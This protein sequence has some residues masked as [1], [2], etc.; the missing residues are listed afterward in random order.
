[1][2]LAYDNN[3]QGYFKYS[4]AELTLTSTRDL[5]SQEVTTLSLW[6]RGDPTNA[7]ERLYVVIANRTGAPAVAYHDDASATQIG[8]WTQWVIPLPAF[9]NQG[10]NLTDVDRIAIGLG[11]IGNTTIPGGSGKIYFDDIRLYR[12]G[13]AT[14]E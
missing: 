11:T 13:A 7:A 9:A 4:E 12:P 14:Q 8:T 2:P 10:V 1:M 5:T 6:F 3:K